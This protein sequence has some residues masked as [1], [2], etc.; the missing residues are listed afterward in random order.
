[1]IKLVTVLTCT[2]FF[3]MTAFKWVIIPEKIPLSAS[4][5]TKKKKERK[6]NSQYCAELV[7][8]EQVFGLFSHS[9]TLPKPL[10]VLDTAFTP[11]TT[12]ALRPHM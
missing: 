10:L 4:S 9:V 1:M 6:K 12:C 2:I 3:C 5:L 7:S 8:A 11:V